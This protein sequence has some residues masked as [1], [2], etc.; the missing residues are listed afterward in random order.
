MGSKGVCVVIAAFNAKAT[1]GRAVKSALAQDCV[2]EVIVCDDASHDGT[3]TVARLQDDGTGRLLV[4]ELPRNVGPAAA[5]NVA[6]AASRSPY[7]CILDSD[8]YFLAGRVARLLDAD[9]GEWDMIADDILIVPENRDA[10]ETFAPGSEPP[11]RSMELRLA[12]FVMANISRA[13]Q[14]RKEWGF[15][16]PL[17]RREF[18]TRHDLR[19]DESLRLGEDYAFYVRAL[20]AGARFKVVGACGYVAI[21]R[22]TSLSSRHSGRDLEAIAE[23]DARCLA[24]EPSLTSSERA[25]IAA[26]LDATRLK[27]NYRTI[28]EIRK[29]RG[30]VPALVALLRV[31]SVWLYVLAETL[32]AKTVMLMSR[33]GYQ[34]RGGSGPRLL[35][36]APSIAPEP[37]VGQRAER[38]LRVSIGSE[39]T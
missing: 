26:H 5:R 27:S 7:I 12:A 29:E 34:M 24:S 28:L 33:F 14:S 23:F 25:A 20:I 17:M 15:L 31:P 6:F 36:G 11:N 8:D 3:A 35:V 13:G 19:Y 21:E 30:L 16:K 4:H 22:D 1:I 32:R 10:T 18:L 37:D 2:E 38:M 39:R 9:V